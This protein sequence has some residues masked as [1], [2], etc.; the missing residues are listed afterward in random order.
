MGR[1]FLVRLILAPTAIV[2]FFPY[3]LLPLFLLFFTPGLPYLRIAPP[4]LGAGGADLLVGP[5]DVAQ[6]A[7]PAPVGAGALDKGGTAPELV[8]Q[9]APVQRLVRRPVVYAPAEHRLEETREDAVP[10]IAHDVLYPAIAE[11][12]NFGESKKGEK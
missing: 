8:A 11:M 4:F 5:F 6:D 12:W 9:R 10:Q 3:R 2:F 7:G 1:G